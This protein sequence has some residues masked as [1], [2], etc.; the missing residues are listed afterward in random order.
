MQEV[1]EEFLWALV[2]S[3]EFALAAKIEG[4]CEIMEVGFV[5]ESG[6]LMMATLLADEV[7][8]T[9]PP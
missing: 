3:T 7:V 1:P 6:L 9:P 8:H 4:C 5:F 2:P